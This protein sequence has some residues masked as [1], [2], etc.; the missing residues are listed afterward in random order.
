MVFEVKFE[1]DIQNIEELLGEKNSIYSPTFLASPDDTAH[2]WKV[3]M[4]IRSNNVIRFCLCSDDKMFL[5]NISA[6]VDMR[7]YDNSNAVVVGWAVNK[8]YDFNETTKLWGVRHNSGFKLHSLKKICLSVELFRK[9]VDCSM[10]SAVSGVA[11]L[12]RSSHKSTILQEHNHS[13]QLKESN[14]LKKPIISKPEPLDHQSAKALQEDLLKLYKTKSFSD[15][16]I[17]CNGHDFK[18]H[19]SILVSRSDHFRRILENEEEK[20]PSEVIQLDDTDPE[21]LKSCLKFLYTGSIQISPH[22]VVDVLELSEKLELHH[23]SNI[24]KMEM[25]KNLSVSTVSKFLISADKHGSQAMKMN[26]IKFIKANLQEV[27][28]NQEFKTSMAK[29]S[30]LMMDILSSV[31]CKEEEGV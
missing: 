1:W 26:A 24:C 15:L 11:I 16:T 8:I 29:R 14:A 31:A 20:N 27:I 30:D 7:V 10:E 6:K 23:L 18:V 5:Q 21:A 9:E 3:A 13:T 25:V 22:I 2:R 17:T 4:E 19:K 28:E 12:N